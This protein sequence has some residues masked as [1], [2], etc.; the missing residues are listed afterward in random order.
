[1]TTEVSIRRPVPADRQALKDMIGRCSPDSI[2]QRFHGYRRSFPA[3]YLT[4]ALGGDDRHFALVA[5]SAG[6]SIVALASCVL[7]ADDA[8][9]IAVLVEDGYQRH[10]IGS[11]MLRMLIGYTDHRG[12][13]TV[14][15]TVLAEQEWILQLL[16]GYGSCS[17]T[18]SM[19]VYEVTLRREKGHRAWIG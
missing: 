12:I 8:A 16:R 7:V 9:D 3:Q 15:A 18:L 17:T 5:E 19:G 2:R 13:A 14:Q 6:T 11:T 1:V 4:G 10:G